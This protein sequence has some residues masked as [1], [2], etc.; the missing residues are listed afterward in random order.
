MKRIIGAAIAACVLAWAGTASAAVVFDQ[1]TYSYGPMTYADQ[2]NYPATGT[3][4]N[5]TVASRPAILD[6]ALWFRLDNFTIDAVRISNATPGNLVRLGVGNHVIG[7][8]YLGV[9][10]AD[11]TFDWTGSLTPVQGKYNYSFF[12][13]IVGP[14]INGRMDYATRFDLDQLTFSGTIPGIV[15]EPATWAMMI[16]G[17]GGV[18]SM[19]RR[20]RQRV[21]IA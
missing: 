12:H 3:P 8:D 19:L 11:G 21:L 17:F 6:A 9:V 13:I 10:G 2:A 7:D 4:V 16:I 14:L 20:S 5:M 1:W 15:P 18:G